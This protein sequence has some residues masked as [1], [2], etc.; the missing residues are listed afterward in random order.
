MKFSLGKKHEDVLSE[1]RL[2]GLFNKYFNYSKGNP[3]TALYAWISHIKSASGGHLEIISPE[4]LN[5]SVFENILDDWQVVLYQVLLHKRMNISKLKNV[6]K[7]E[8]NEILRITDVL[9]IAGLIK[10]KSNG[11]YVINPYVDKFL[12]EY[13]LQDN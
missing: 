13:L 6:L 1:I 2:A 10:E 11:L 5:T 3:G 7:L 12:T 9:N 4:N 8:K